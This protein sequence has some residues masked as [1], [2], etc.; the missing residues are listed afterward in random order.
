MCRRP[1]VHNLGFLWVGDV[2]GHLMSRT[3][4]GCERQPVCI[5]R[6]RREHGEGG[7]L[8]LPP[9]NSSSRMP[10]GLAVI[11]CVAISSSPS[12]VWEIL[13]WR[14]LARMSGIA[15]ST[16]L[17]LHNRFGFFAMK[18]NKSEGGERLFEVMDVGPVEDK[19][20]GKPSLKILSV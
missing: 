8:P 17:T 1:M 19:R 4:L 18:R 7:R 9:G 2:F 16:R 13:S 6:R 20:W 15:S 5:P 12:C 10:E 11:L 14:E 3:W